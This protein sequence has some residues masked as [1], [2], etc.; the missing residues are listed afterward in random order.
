M[1]K[2]EAVGLLASGIAH[3]FNNILFAILGYADLVKDEVR[4]GSTAIEDL[5]ELRAAGLRGKELVSQLLVFTRQAEHELKAL[6]LSSAV[7]DALKFL[8][9]TL[10]TTISI[11]P[12]L[13]EADDLVMANPTQ[14][15]QVLMNLCT[16]AWHA[17][18]DG[19]ELEVSVQPVEVDEEFAVAHEGLSPGPTL[20]LRVSDTGTGMSRETAE[21]I[22]EPFFT[23]KETGVGTGLGLSVV[24]GIIKS[25]G[26]TIHAYSE[27]G[28]GTSFHIYL[29]RLSS[30]GG[31]GQAQLPER[32]APRG[33]ERIMVVDDD[34]SLMK[35]LSRILSR[36]G[37]QVSAFSNAQEAL[38]AFRAEPD[39]YDLVFT[40]HTM[41]GLTGLQFARA[42][43]RLRPR[44]PVILATGFAHHN[45]SEEALV[46]GIARVVTKPLVA[47]ALA[48]AVRAALDGATD[49]QA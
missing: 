35:M 8:R 28:Q 36:L 46:A 39:Q 38:A 40:D 45:L 41:P 16:N 10:P 30:A 19:G 25:M 47:E 6:S 3:D 4:A 9:A 33:T 5:E 27:L 11:R 20:L 13:P 12:L 15:H 22:F 21:R 26:G 34:A 1:Q 49:P 44:L 24:Y 17:M 32:S 7:R 23:T 37:Y 2:M 18:P 48:E 31:T 42:V 43:L 14:L 29:P